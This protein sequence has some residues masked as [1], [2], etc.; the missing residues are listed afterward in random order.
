MTEH[1]DGWPQDQPDVGDWDADGPE[2]PEP[3]PFGLEDGPAVGRLVEDLDD[4]DPDPYGADPAAPEPAGGVDPYVSDDPWAGDGGY[5]D[6][7]AGFGAADEPAAAEVP[8]QVGFG[9]ADPPVGAD[10]DA[11]PYGDPARWWPP[12]GPEPF[13]G[14]VGALPEPVDGFPWVDPDLLGSARGGPEPAEAVVAEAPYPDDLADYAA[15]DLP[16][17]GDPWSTL[18]ASDDPATSALARFWAPPESR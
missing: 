9:S 4:V 12:V 16:V 1:W 14:F 5:P 17:D 10:P 8:A 13:G 11:G 15:V 7:E 2:V 3:G 6:A 18:A